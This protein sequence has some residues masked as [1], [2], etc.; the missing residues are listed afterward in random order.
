MIIAAIITAVVGIVAIYVSYYCN[1]NLQQH[2]II[3]EKLI[4]DTVKIIE[5]EEFKNML[6]FFKDPSSPKNLISKLSEL[7]SLG[8]SLKERGDDFKE[9]KDDFGNL[10]G[11][12]QKVRTRLADRLF[13]PV[14]ARIHEG[15]EM[16]ETFTT[17]LQVQDGSKMFIRDNWLQ[18]P[19]VQRIIDSD[20]TIFIE[21][22][23]TLA[24]CVLSLI[25]CIE[26]KRKSDK[27][28]HVCT[29]NVAI[30]MML[31]FHKNI[32]SIL[33]P[34]KPDNPYAA[35]F[36]DIMNDGSHKDMVNEFL[37]EHDVK[38]VISTASFLDIDYGPHVSSDQNHAIK[39][40]LNEYTTMNNLTNIFIIAAEKI[41]Q[42]VTNA[43]IAPNCLLIFDKTRTR[44]VLK[45]DEVLKKSKIEW[46]MH[47]RN[48]NNI[49]VT[50]SNDKNNIKIIECFER[51]HNMSS[52][53]I[54][55]KDGFLSMIPNAKV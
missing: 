39:R 44:D 31:L 42:D 8:K 22:G 4:C 35:T 2:R 1:K 10:K 49:I 54:E 46:E 55:I 51:M 6:S 34:G 24:Y 13:N 47:I 40:M 45:H 15:I 32:D 30:H 26:K 5:S 12:V 36:G 16:N 41:N 50:G 37:K 23:S 7:S 33:L 9:L 3:L 48:L 19:I 27:P 20:D 38:V 29:N 17:R 14:I 11:E 25:E 28:L 21:S 53:D 52:F 18:I 43:C